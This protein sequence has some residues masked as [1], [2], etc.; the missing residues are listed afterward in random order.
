VPIIVSAKL[1]REPEE[2]EAV[3]TVRVE[4]APPEVG[5]RVEGEKEK[6]A[7]DGSPR[8]VSVSAGITPVDP[9]TSFRVTV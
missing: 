9:D 8:T 2:P 3:F 6:V 4:F 7:S 1:P 5:T